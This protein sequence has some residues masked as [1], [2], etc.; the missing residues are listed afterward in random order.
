MAR[1]GEWEAGSGDWEIRTLEGRSPFTKELSQWIEI[2]LLLWL[3]IL[4]AP[5]I[6]NTTTILSDLTSFFY[7]NLSAKLLSPLNS[8]YSISIN[9]LINLL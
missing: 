1:R 9:A 2:F 8:Y 7:P 3:R 4:I 5:M 6:V